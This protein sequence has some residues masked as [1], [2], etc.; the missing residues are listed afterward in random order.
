MN[1]KILNKRIV[2]SCLSFILILSM[3]FGFSFVDIYK[4]SNENN[5][6][7]QLQVYKVQ[8]IILHLILQM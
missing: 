8:L 4:V 3:I 1:K 5:A 6:K 2:R 7:A